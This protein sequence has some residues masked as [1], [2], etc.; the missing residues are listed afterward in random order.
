MSI[1]HVPFASFWTTALLVVLAF[2]ARSFLAAFIALVLGSWLGVRLD[3]WLR[4]HP[5]TGGRRLRGM[6]G[7]S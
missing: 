7:V 4:R 3:R 2:P 5:S 6:L 1:E